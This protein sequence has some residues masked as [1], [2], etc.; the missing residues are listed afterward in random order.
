MEGIE[1]LAEGQAFMDAADDIFGLNHTLGDAEISR[2]RRAWIAGRDWARRQAGEAQTLL[3]V[4]DDLRRAAEA[5]LKS[6][7]IEPRRLYRKHL[8]ETANV[9]IERAEFYEQQSQEKD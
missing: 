6:A 2:L 5:H 3:F 8:T 4:A 9:L 1:S 7:D